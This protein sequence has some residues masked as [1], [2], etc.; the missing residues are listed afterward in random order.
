[1]DEHIKALLIKYITGNA[2]EDE[3]LQARQWMRESEDHLD[4]FM[5]L[6]AAWQDALHHPGEQ[7]INTDQAFSRL[8]SRLQIQPAEQPDAGR[9]ARHFA[10][11]RA[12]K[13]AAAAVLVLTAGGIGLRLLL[14]DRP[15]PVQQTAFEIFVPRG[16]MK[17]L[18][19]PD[20]SEIWLNAG[21]RFGYAAGFGEYQ[22][23]V[24]LDGEAWFAVK[25]NEK[26]PF[27]VKARGYTV[28]DIGT[29]FTIS[30]Y[31][32]NK[33]F[34]TAV[35]EGRVEVTGDLTLTNKTG[36]VF[37]AKNEVLKIARNKPI[38]DKAA[39]TVHP[40][41]PADKTPPP[42]GVQALVNTVPDMESYSGWKD[43]LLVFNEETF[44]DVAQRLERTYDVK[45]HISSKQLASFRYTGRFNKVQSIADA[46][47]IIKETTPITYRRE[48]DVI[49]I[50]M[51]KK[52]H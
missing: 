3:Q 1:M 38:Q 44:S 26:I 9:S 18:L 34:E 31:P 42:I 16:K 19:L 2:D 28:R 49:I 40:A 6:K 5:S 51:D 22:R 32:D 10:W 25:H 47:A 20:S 7:V 15:Q 45:L 41:G 33:N 23:E 36:K 30:A 48:K 17:K 11:P 27:T 21:T 37:L 14:K 13:I 46:L 52:Q 35:I 39:P 43:H 50:S 12:L 4:Y 8:Q 24:F 29:V